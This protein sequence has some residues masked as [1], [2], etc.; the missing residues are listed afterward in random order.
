MVFNAANPLF[1]ELDWIMTETPRVNR[2]FRKM[3]SYLFT[4]ILIWLVILLYRYNP[5]YEKGLRSDTQAT[6][7]Y[8]ALAYTCASAVFHAF[9]R[10]KAGSP[11]TGLIIF[12]AIRRVFKDAWHYWGHFTT[13]PDSIR[14]ALEKH[15][16]TAILF[17]VVKIHFLPMML[18]AF[19]AVFFDVMNLIVKAAEWP[20]ELLTVDGF[21]SIT[22]PIVVGIVFLIDTGYFS[23][24]YAVEAGFLKNRVRSVE[25]TV[26]GWCV[27]L[28][29]Y[30]PFKSMFCQ[31][32]GWFPDY[33]SSTHD[34]ATTFIMRVSVA[35]LLLVYA[36][37]TIALGAKCSNLTNRGIVVDGPY[38][39]VRH[40]S[41][42]SKN[43]AWWITVLPVM[44]FYVF[45]SMLSWSFIYYLRAVTEERHLIA[46][47]EYVEYCR[48]VRYRFIPYVW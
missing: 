23:F 35:L 18:N 41:Y 19:Y 4:T 27:A 43:L 26:F 32:T 5:Y 48:R 21:N 12:S 14:P 42:A 13:K 20:G 38:R 7:L 24:G 6:L 10:E 37:T 33:M 39:F 11:G 45:L 16:K 34:A 30:M 8:L 46:D 47:P 29:C 2:F 28:S 31:Y 25:P 22:Y 3:K 36:V 15:E 9:R 17:M 40:P 1:P 44:S